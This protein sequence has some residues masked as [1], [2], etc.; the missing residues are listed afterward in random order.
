MEFIEFKFN[1]WEDVVWP[2]VSISSILGLW[3]IFI[4]YRP[5]GVKK[6]LNNFIN[7][8]VQ[9]YDYEDKRDKKCRY[10]NSADE[11]IKRNQKSYQIFKIIHPGLKFESSDSNDS[12]WFKSVHLEQKNKQFYYYMHISKKE[13]NKF[14]NQA[15]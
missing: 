6:K 8:I 7:D 13:L 12:Q 5:N 9:I 15:L 4:D 14:K 11:Y 1:I 10:M 3:R 2:L